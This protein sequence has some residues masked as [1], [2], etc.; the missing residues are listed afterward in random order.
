MTPE[1][2]QRIASDPAAFQSALI[3][4]SSK[5]P[6]PFGDIMADFQRERFAQIGAA[7]VSVARGETPAIG[8]YFWEATKGASKDSDLAVCLLWLLAFTKRPLFCQVGAA[9]QDQA[10]ELRKAAKAIL[11]LN[12]WLAE[13]ITVQS[14]QIVSART[15]SACEVIAADVAGSHGARPDVLIL[16]ELSHIGKKEF[17]ET[18]LDNA[19][20]VPHGL[21][22][23][24]TNGGFV[25]S[26]QHDW[27]ELARVSDRWGFHQRSEPAPWLDPAEIDEARRRNPPA[28]FNRLWAGQWVAQTGDA[29]PSN[30]IDRAIGTYA[31]AAGGLRPGCMQPVTMGVDLALRRDRAAIAISCLLDEGW[32]QGRRPRV[33]IIYAQSWRPPPGGEIILDE[34]EAAIV[35]ACRLYHCGQIVMDPWNAGQLGQHLGAMG[36]D[37]RPIYPTVANLDAQA[38]HLFNGFRDGLFE[39]PTNCPELIADLKKLSIIERPG[40]GQTSFRITAPRDLMGHCDLASAA[41][42][43]LTVSSVYAQTMTPPRETHHYW[44]NYPA[45]GTVPPGQLGAILPQGYVNDLARQGYNP[46]TAQRIDLNR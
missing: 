29:I 22:C 42:L 26:W 8:R 15:D 21:V 43:C 6:R 10:D 44:D 1:L 39:L 9:D 17:A 40:V 38:M 31:V 19:A 7:L 13:V 12:P 20:K 2:F 35:H 16:N 45:A 41:A 32:R 5:G 37:A 33:A 14:W 27:R 36:F 18:L 30:L 25:P 11:R 28:R 23:I 46:S 34:V 4:P 24:A 3:V